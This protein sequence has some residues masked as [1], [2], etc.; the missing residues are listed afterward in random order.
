MPRQDQPFT[1]THVRDLTAAPV[2]NSAIVSADISLFLRG[3]IAHRSLAI[4]GNRDRFSAPRGYRLRD[5]R[6]GERGKSRYRNGRRV[7]E[8]V[9]LLQ[10]RPTSCVMKTRRE[11]PRDDDKHVCQA[12]EQRY[13]F[14]G[15][16]S[17]DCATLAARS[18]LSSPFSSRPVPGLRLRDAIW[19][20]LR[21][22]RRV[23]RARSSR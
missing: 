2:P 13:S 7:E 4:T 23:R 10:S 1:L 5:S 6:A 15:R 19:L 11:S 14:P 20:N 16:V 3:A 17:R 21:Q 18:A 8:E 22:T 9:R 12:E